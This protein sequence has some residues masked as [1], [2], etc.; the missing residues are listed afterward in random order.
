MEHR[1]GGIDLECLDEGH[2]LAR[3]EGS[4]HAFEVVNLLSQ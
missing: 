2:P 1:Y 4:D 3:L